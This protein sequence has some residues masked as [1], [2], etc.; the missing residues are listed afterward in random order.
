MRGFLR[1]CVG[2]ALTCIA[3][4]AAAQQPLRAWT[5]AEDHQHMLTQ[6]GIS[7]LRPGPSGNESAPDHA[8]YDELLA[9]PFPVLPDALALKD[10][11]GVTSSRQW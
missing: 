6:L 1:F 9:N 2:A 3:V 4:A 5:T 10:G 7:R 8:N 11:R